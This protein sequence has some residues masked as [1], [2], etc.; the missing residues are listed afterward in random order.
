M[1]QPIQPIRVI[2]ADDHTL[3]R[4]GMRVLLE[5]LPGVEVVGEASEGREALRLVR[6]HRPDVVLMDISMP[7]LNGLEAARLIRKEKP[8]PQ[9]V[10]ITQHDSPQIRS[11][12]IEAGARAFVTKSA[13][14]NEL[15]SALRGL[16]LD[17]GN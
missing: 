12:A 7:G 3:V 10:I 16:I 2:L 8:G 17:Q 6:K 1:S 14:A 5:K 9:I 11:A 13:V 15:V 4:A